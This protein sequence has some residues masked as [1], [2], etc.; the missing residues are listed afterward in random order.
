MS[1]HLLINRLDRL[2]KQCSHA[3]QQAAAQAAASAYQEAR[4]LVPVRTGY[5]RSTLRAGT[6]GVFTGCSYALFVET[7]TRRMHARPYLRPAAHG[8]DF[9][10]YAARA[11]KEAIL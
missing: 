10:G 6:H 5:L 4:A 1:V 11:L 9:P 8:A 2:E 3:L 7:G